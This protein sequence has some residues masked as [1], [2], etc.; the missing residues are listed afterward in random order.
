MAN[1][2]GNSGNSDRFYFLELQKSLWTVT[3]AIK[4]KDSCY[5]CFLN[6]EI[7]AA[8]FIEVVGALLSGV[9]HVLC[10]NGWPCPKA[11]CLC[12]IKMHWTSYQ[13][14]APGFQ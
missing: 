6:S 10:E 12:Q 7:T 11:G 13:I 1:R 14:R 8:P 3:A 2:W 9:H 4:L 5:K